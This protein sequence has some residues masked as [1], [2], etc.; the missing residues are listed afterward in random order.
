MPVTLP[1]CRPSAQCRKA[2]PRGG[3]HRC[4]ARSPSARTRWRGDGERRSTASRSLSR[5][6]RAMT[7]AVARPARPSNTFRP[8]A[9][10]STLKYGSSQWGTQPAPPPWSPS[11]SPSSARRPARP[12]RH[13]ATT[14]G[15]T[16]S[17]PAAGRRSGKR[18]Y[19][20]R[21]V[22]QVALIDLLQVAGLSIGE[23]RA[24]VSPTGNLRRRLAPAGGAED[25]PHRATSSA[26]S[27]SPNRSS[28][29][30]SNCP[31]A[32]TRRMP[33]VPAGRP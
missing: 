4:P 26:S 12:P 31:H 2:V 14:N 16:C 21:S 1:T 19:P 20:A 5:F 18:V 7:F 23:I 33:D 11:P 30:P 28:S 22:E 27:N 24:I 10:F 13:S 9:R 15:S 32:C 6:I 3:R 17:S 8:M 25:R 29:T